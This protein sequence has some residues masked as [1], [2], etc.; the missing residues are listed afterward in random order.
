MQLLMLV[1][2]AAG[3]NTMAHSDEQSAAQAVDVLMKHGP[4]GAGLVTFRA[5]S[6]ESAAEAVKHLANRLAD[7]PPVIRESLENGR[8]SAAMLSPDRLQGLS[9]MIQNADDAEASQVRVALLADGLWV[10]HDG[11]PIELEHV[12]GIAIPW[13][14]TKSHDAAATGRHGIGLMTLRSLS[15]VLAG[16]L[17]AL[18]R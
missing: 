17:P 6:A 18:P 8:N 1:G 5:K 16:A 9:E 13:I 3:E 7:V 14:T 4:K 11:S 10:A 2:Q 15:P 12:F